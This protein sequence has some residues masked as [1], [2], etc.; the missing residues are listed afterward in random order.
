[1][2]S[3][4]SGDIREELR[5]QVLDKFSDNVTSFTWRLET[6]VGVNAN[7]RSNVGATWMICYPRACTFSMYAQPHTD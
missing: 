3:T 1:M 4:I 6:L 7:C 5:S 2:Q